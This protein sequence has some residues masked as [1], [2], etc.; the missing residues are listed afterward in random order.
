MNLNIISLYNAASYIISKLTGF[1]SVV[2][3]LVVVMT[4]PFT[5]MIKSDKPNYTRF[6]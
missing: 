5:V 6:I 2:V 1:D 3:V 4:A